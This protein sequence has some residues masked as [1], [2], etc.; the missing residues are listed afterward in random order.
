MAPDLLGP[1]CLVWGA[2]PEAASE[3]EHVMG[4]IPSLMRYQEEA[5]PVVR[6]SRASVLVLIII[7]MAVGL[8]IFMAAL[9]LGWIN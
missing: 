1:I 9:F 6:K 3:L 7:G 2:A 4:H 8:A 5:R